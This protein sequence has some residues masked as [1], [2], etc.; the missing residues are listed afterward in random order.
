MM[1]KV[2]FAL[3]KKLSSELDREKLTRVKPVQGLD[4][5]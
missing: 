2:G 5:K 4:L 1:A 3:E